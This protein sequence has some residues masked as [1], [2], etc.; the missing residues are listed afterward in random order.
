MNTKRIKELQKSIIKARR[1][2]YNKESK[3][4]DKLFDAWI[5][6]LKLIDPTNVAIT[7]IGYQVTPSVWTKAKHAIGMGSLDKVNTP[8]ELKKWSQVLPHEKLFCTE[9]LDGISINCAYESGK[10]IQCI[11]RGDGFIGEDIFVNVKR[12]SGAQEN[13][14]SDFTGSIRADCSPR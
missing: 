7:S 3:V 4:S 11:T 14:K 2:Y 6:E 1:D 5:D 12:M 9:K 10:L 8:E 13:L